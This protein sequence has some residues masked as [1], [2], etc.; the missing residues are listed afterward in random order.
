MILAP[1]LIFCY[2]R[3]DTL[4]QT[5]TAL[6]N[7][8][9]S[10]ESDLIIFSDGAKNKADEK[11]VSEVR[12]FIKTISGFKRII[13]KENQENKGLAAS[14]IE[15]VTEIINVV[16]KVIVLEDDLIVSNN[17]LNFMNEA[18][19]YY[20]TN[21]SIFS[22][23]GY[24]IPIKSKTKDDVYFTKRGSSWGWAT[25]KDRWNNID[26]EVDD[27]SI[28]I[29]DRNK[30]KDFN[31]MGSD[32]SSM[33]KKQM[34][35]QINSW[36]IRWVFHQF[37]QNLYTVYPIKS[38]VLNEGF[39]LSATHTTKIH[40][41]RFITDLDDTNK[42]SFSFPNEPFLDKNVVSQFVQV[43]SL[44]TRMKYKLKGFLS[45]LLVKKK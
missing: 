17:F 28:F 41:N 29:K 2:K 14:I 33:L 32:L 11:Q 8:F 23:S 21:K 38:K 10:L 40:A 34:E 7:N 27:Y 37:N 13:I 9:L 1:V 25:W 26:W 45:D 15:G 36:A 18:L 30:H 19:H 24:S 43:Y 39:G 44:V 5:I 3:L 35:G 22:I 4:Q 6:K 42:Y 12:A 31:K 16:D 20:Q